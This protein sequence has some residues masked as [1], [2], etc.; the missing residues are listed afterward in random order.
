MFRSKQNQSFSG[1]SCQQLKLLVESL[2]NDYGLSYAQICE[3]SSYSMAMVARHSLGSYAQ[4]G[5]VAC[6]VNDSLAGWIVLATCRHLVNAGAKLK[7]Y[8]NGPTNSLEIKN[9]IKPLKQ[10]GVEFEELIGIAQ[11]QSLANYLTNCHNILVGLYALET[12]HI[13]YKADYLLYKTIELINELSTPAH[14][15]LLPFGVDPIDGS[16]SEVRLYAASTLSIGAPLAV[17]KE[18]HV[19]A[20]RI[21]LCDISIS[22]KLYQSIGLNL[23]VLFSEQPVVQ[24][25]L[26]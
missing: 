8:L 16:T 12:Q 24:V 23:G 9:Q 3:A 4:D 13:D 25:F 10:L 22:Q 17:L 6:L 20:G 5:Q 18:A 2:Q 14:C 26:E 7:I 1:I 19:F 15:A 11:V 21:Y